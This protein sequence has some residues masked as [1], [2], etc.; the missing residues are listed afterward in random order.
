MSDHSAIHLHKATKK[1]FVNVK[2]HDGARMRGYI[3]VSTFDR[4]QD[5]LNDDRP[6]I[7]LHMVSGNGGLIM[8]SKRYIV[9]MEEQE[10]VA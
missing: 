9:T 10:E 4:L 3:Y 2:M 7:P 8:L 6:F 1:V 5:L